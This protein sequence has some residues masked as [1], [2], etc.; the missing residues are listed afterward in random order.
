MT[1]VRLHAPMAGWAA[2]LDE[3]P[4]PVFAE[5]M[6]GEGLAIDPVEA[7]IRAPCDAE[8]IAV[9]ETRHAV[10]LRLD[11]GAELLIHVGLETVGLGGDGFTASVVAGQRVRTG[12][13]LIAFDLDGVADRATSL[14]SPIVVTNEGYK[15][16]LLAVGQAVT[17]G[18]PIA[19][20]EGAGQALPDPAATGASERAELVIGAA[21]GIHARPAARIAAAAKGFAASLE[22]EAKGGKANARSPVALMTLAL[23]KGD[24]VVLIARGPD[25]AAALAALAP[26]VESD[27]DEPEPEPAR[28]R[29]GRAARGRSGS[30]SRRLCSARPGGR[31]GRTVHARADRGRREGVRNIRRAQGV[32]TSA[33]RGGRPPRL[34]GGRQRR[35]RRGTSGPA[36]RSRITD[37]YRGG[38]R[39]RPQRRLCLARRDRGERGSPARHRQC[40]A[41]RADR[42]PRRIWNASCSP[43]SRARR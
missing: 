40:P 21:L 30:H 19:E 38:H 10:T 9:P 42:R 41:D 6:M 8:V 5:G 33:R 25:A 3:V 4:D 32:R 11:N 37:R 28:H 2:P 12:D 43:R 1:M 13:P 20:V 36:R 29:S 16:R 24:P 14:I 26:L 27:F 23:A 39:R 15:V 17:A 35:H 34:A 7:V 22:V 18:D 31:S